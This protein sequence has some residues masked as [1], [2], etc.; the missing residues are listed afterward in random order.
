MND[1]VCKVCFVKLEKYQKI[2]CSPVCNNKNRKMSKWRIS[3]LLNPNKC[4]YCNSSI[5]P[6]DGA[7][8]SETKVKKFCNHSC[9]ASYNNRNKNSNSNKNVEVSCK[10]C[11]IIFYTEGR[12]KICEKC[13]PA[14]LNKTKG[15]LFSKSSHYHSARGMIQKNARKIAQEKEMKCVVCGY[16]KYVE[17]AHIRSVS[18][19]PDTAT[20]AEINDIKNL[21]ILCP[22]H[23]WEYD[24]QLIFLT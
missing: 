15:E 24:H 4:L 1:L 10:K 19:F 17:I 11:F 13:N 22:N 21:T 14:I 5:L 9:A 18:S 3:Y 2:V 7:K 8:L 20:V 6:V 12:S 16:D 23:H